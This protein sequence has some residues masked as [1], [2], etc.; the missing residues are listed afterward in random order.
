MPAPLRRRTPGRAVLALV[1]GSLLATLAACDQSQAIR[2]QALQDSKAVT[3]RTSDGVRLAGRIFG[4]DTASA[5]VVL[6]HMLPADQSSWFDFADRLGTSGYRVLTF[7]FRGYCPGGD[8]GCS[9]GAK[10]VGST[11][12]DVLSAAAYLRAQGP[13]RLTFVGASMGGTA[14]LVAAAQHPRGLEGVATLSAPVQID[15]LTAGPDTMATVSVPKLFMAGDSDPNDAA[16]SAQQLYDESLQPK[17]L[18]LFTTADHGT[19]LLSG[20]QGEQSRNALLTW[21]A[22]YLPVAPPSTTP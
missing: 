21:L 18:T 5:G 2:T 11:W 1:V 4:P 14:S 7:D 10:D 16:T 6:A 15:G 19:D 22:Q 8:A 13:N 3:F 20:N 9:E 17:R 12:Q